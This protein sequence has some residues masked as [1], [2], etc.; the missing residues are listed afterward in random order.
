MHLII[1]FMTTTGSSTNKALL[2]VWISEYD[3]IAQNTSSISSH[4][5]SRYLML[6]ENSIVEQR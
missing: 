3:L 4:I 1:L 2:A 5:I 6:C